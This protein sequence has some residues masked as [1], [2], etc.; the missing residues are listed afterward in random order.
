[1]LIGSYLKLLL[2]VFYH[3]SLFSELYILILS[4]DCENLFFKE[5]VF[6]VF[7]HVFEVSLTQFCLVV[8]MNNLFDVLSIS[9]QY[10]LSFNWPKFGL[11]CLVTITLKGQN[12]KFKASVWNFPISGK[13]RN[14]NSIFMLVDNNSIIIMEQ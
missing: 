6:K 5:N 4:G 14:C 1:M 3:R 8:L 9:L 7:L 10:F 12:L 2:N 11:K 13:G